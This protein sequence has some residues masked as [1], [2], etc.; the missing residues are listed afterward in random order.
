MPSP[1]YICLPKSMIAYSRER[2]HKKTYT[3][4]TIFKDP[5]P[6][7]IT[8][9]SSKIISMNSI[10]TIG[11]IAEFNPFHKG[12]EHIIN[13]A[14]QHFGASHV[15]VIMSGDYVQ[16][17]EP[18]IIDK[19]ARTKMALTAGADMVFE[20][21]TAFASGS[22][23]YFARGAV[24]ALINCTC[25]D[26]LL[27]GSECGRIE[28]LKELASGNTVA[29]EAMSDEPANGC[30]SPTVVHDG[31]FTPRELRLSPNDLLAVEY[32][33][34]IEYFGADITP[35]TIPRRAVSHT[36]VLPKEGFASASAIREMLCG[37]FSDGPNDIKE[38]IPSYAFDML[39]TYMAEKQPLSPGSFS[40]MLFSTLI[41]ER[42][43]GYADYFDIFPDLSDKIRTKL[44]SY[45]DY[46]SFINVLKS[47]DISYS[48]LSRALLHILL[49]I[50]KEDVDMM[51]DKYGYCPWLRLLGLKRE[52][53]LP[54]GL[55]SS[56]CRS[57]ISRLADAKDIL[58]PDALAL[59]KKD[60][61]ASDLYCYTAN[62]NGGFV[63]EYRRGI[64]IL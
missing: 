42:S 46:T 5:L 52:S 58:E 29:D 40:D 26:A 22:A 53:T 50:K 38:F 6:L 21:P 51:R 7:K 36:D 48:H 61:A 10:N 19:Y 1:T 31:R 8:A 15:I 55:R 28:I 64:V 63:S 49:D 9:L 18:A 17:G 35:L 62:K 3:F 23:Q 4:I 56:A 34:A 32:I 11:I 45:K 2:C 25:V 59:L 54:S 60:I 43:G 27:F 30:S 33:K 41:R 47:K 57:I 12:H 39:E 44:E 13:E 16:R 37:S 14:R 20:L 24:S